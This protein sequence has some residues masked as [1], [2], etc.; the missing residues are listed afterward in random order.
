MIALPVRLALV[1]LLVL[2]SAACGLRSSP[3]DGLR[4][5]PPAGWNP[6]PGIL[7]FMQFWRSPG[8]D[9]EFLILFRSPRP[10]QTKEMFSSQGMQDSMKDVTVLREQS[11]KIC[12]NQPATFVLARGDS[13]RSGP[14]DIESIATNIGGASYFATYIRPVSAPPNPEAMA[15]L[16]ELCTKP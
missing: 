15:S 13:A 6:S 10:M 9:R 5:Q 3:A 14:T 2:S 4:F 12:G 11:I 8:N 16:R 1:M 7:G